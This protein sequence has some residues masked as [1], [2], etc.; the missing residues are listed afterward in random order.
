MNR[1]SKP[2][3]CLYPECKE[4]GV[5]FATSNDLDRHRKSDKHKLAPTK[6]S[7]KG[8]I[9]CACPVLPDGTPKWWNRLDN[10]RSHV[11]RK[12]KDMNKQLVVRMYEHL[13]L[14][15]DCVAVA[16]CDKIGLSATLD[17]S[18]PSLTLATIQ[19]TSLVP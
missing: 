11:D 1:H 18:T 19:H 7:G 2:Y 13:S 17:Q 3:R 12:H 5:G 10:F 6:G 14:Q 9:C 8:Y 16:D 15:R 4:K